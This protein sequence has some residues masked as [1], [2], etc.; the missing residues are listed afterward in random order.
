VSVLNKVDYLVIIYIE[1]HACRVGWW[2]SSVRSARATGNP[3]HMTA[4]F[5]VHKPLL[6]LCWSDIRHDP[7]TVRWLIYQLKHEPRP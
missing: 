6:K 7:C 4:S 5:D 2:I 3:R 1:C